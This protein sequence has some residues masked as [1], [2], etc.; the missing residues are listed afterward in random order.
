MQSSVLKNKINKHENG[1]VQHSNRYFIIRH[2]G[3]WCSNSNSCTSPF[4][5]TSQLPFHPRSQ[6]RKDEMRGLKSVAKISIVSR[7]IS[8]QLQNTWWS[9]HSFI[10]NDALS[11]K[12]NAI[13]SK[14]K[15]I[16]LKMQECNNTPVI[17]SEENQIQDLKK[18]LE[19]KDGQLELATGSWSQ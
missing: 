12:Y 13:H 18:Q 14:I 2:Q 3:K 9:S 15:L 10:H 4:H 16:C 5:P 17:L 1:G 11:H 19:L 7:K 8:T 6:R